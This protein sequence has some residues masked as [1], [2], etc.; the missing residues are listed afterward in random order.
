VSIKK[1][2]T[3][4]VKRGFIARNLRGSFATGVAVT[5]KD[6]VSYLETS[7]T[8]SKFRAAKLAKARRR[9]A[10]K[11]KGW[12]VLHAVSINQLFSK[13]RD[14]IKEPLK[15]FMVKRIL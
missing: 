9:L 10:E 2:V 3:K 11:P 12:K 5:N 1:G 8:R 15:R 14:K 7:E 13:N 6:Y 4:T